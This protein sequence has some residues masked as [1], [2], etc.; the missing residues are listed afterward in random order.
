MFDFF[1]YSGKL[2]DALICKLNKSLLGFCSKWS[3]F[4]HNLFFEYGEDQIWPDKVINLI[5]QAEQRK[6]PTFSAYYIY[7]PIG[8]TRQDYRSDNLEMREEYK[9]HFIK[10]S[11]NAK[12]VLEEIDHLRKKYPKSI[13]I[14][15]GDHGPYLSRGEK[16][17][18]RFIILDRHAVALTLL[19]ASNLCPLS[20]KWLKKQRLL[21]S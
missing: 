3:F 19:N 6:E 11:Q 21:N 9:K 13:F 4:I 16:E 7:S 14:I 10:E 17:D 15:S 2:K 12:K 1:Y 8:H 18:K 5:D 20:K